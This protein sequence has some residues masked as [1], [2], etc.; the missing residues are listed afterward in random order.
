MEELELTGLSREEILYEDANVFI[1][2]IKL[3][4]SST[5]LG[6]VFLIYQKKLFGKGNFY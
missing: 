3:E 6:P 1:Y 4:R 2:Y 5:R